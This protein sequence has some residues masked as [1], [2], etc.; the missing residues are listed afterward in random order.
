LITVDEVVRNKAI[1][2]GAGEWV[3]G[4]DALVAGLAADWDLTVGDVLTGG[5]EAV[6]LAVT[7]GDGTP[8]VLKLCVPRDARAAEREALVLQVADGHGCAR[9]FDADLEREALLLERLGPSMFALALPY[10]RRI[11]L[12][13]DAASALWR[14][15]AEVDLPTGAEKGRWL[16]EH[17]ERLWEALDRPCPRHAVDHAVACAERRVAAHDDERAVL[18]HGDVHQ[19]NAL[20]AGD[21]TFKLID[22]DGLLAEPEYDLAILMREDPD[23]HDALDRAHRLANRTGCN[24]TAIWEW[25]AVER[26]STALLCISIGLQPSGDEMLAEAVRLATSPTPG[27]AA[28][29]D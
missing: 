24:V 20:D 17:I 25:G 13:C 10:E 28:R 15:A 7:R 27:S 3:A 6:V 4:I 16:I 19:W 1:S 29:P 14:P 5:T 11:P 9:L 21:G 23:V 22:P 18:V 26:L 8:A 2:V 12:L